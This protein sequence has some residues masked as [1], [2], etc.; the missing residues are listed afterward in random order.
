MIDLLLF[1]I[2]NP[3]S[4]SYVLPGQHH[5]FHRSLET[6]TLRV[7]LLVLAYP[8]EHPLFCLSERIDDLLYLKPVLEF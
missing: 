2:D 7:L 6:G 5:R 8:A 3:I 1:S 4:D